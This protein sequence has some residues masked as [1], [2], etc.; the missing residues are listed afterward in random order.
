MISRRNFLMAGAA[1]VALPVAGCATFDPGPVVNVLQQVL[2]Y[3]QTICH[4]VGEASAILAFIQTFPVGTAAVV[5][6][7]AICAAIGTPTSRRRFGGRVPYIRLKGGIV[8]NGVNFPTV[9]LR[10]VTIPY[11]NIGTAAGRMMAAMAPLPYVIVNGV[12][13]PV[14][15]SPF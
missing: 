10:H 5:I 2:G 8:I 1:A 12:Q 4:V 13:I 15:P 7:N 11:A 6:A 14:Q 3:L 9:T